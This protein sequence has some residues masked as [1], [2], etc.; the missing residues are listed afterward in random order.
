MTPLRQKP[1]PMMV[2]SWLVFWAVLLALGS[3]HWDLMG[4]RDKSL[5]MALVSA[6]LAAWSMLVRGSGP[7][8]NG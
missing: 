3:V 5:Q 6:S 4:D 2:R 7:S 1:L 8:E